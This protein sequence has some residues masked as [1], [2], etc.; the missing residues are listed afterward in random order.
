LKIQDEFILD[1]STAFFE[2]TDVTNKTV[3][4]NMYGNYNSPDVLI[5]FLTLVAV[6]LEFLA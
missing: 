3:R 2:V 6:E 4:E 1:H 5:T